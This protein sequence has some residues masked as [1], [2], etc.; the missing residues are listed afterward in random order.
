MLNGSGMVE[1][2]FDRLKLSEWN[3]LSILRKSNRTERC[4]QYYFGLYL[5]KSLKVRFFIFQFF[6]N[7]N[8]QKYDLTNNAEGF[9]I[10]RKILQ[11]VIC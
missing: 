5:K 9:L 11:D 2:N 10:Y 8:M 3:L 1:W 6:K 7:N 4:S